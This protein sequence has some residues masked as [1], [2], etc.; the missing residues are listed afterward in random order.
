MIYI[1]SKLIPVSIYGALVTSLTCLYYYTHTITLGAFK[2][3][4]ALFLLLNKLV[5]DIQLAYFK[6]AYQ[7]AYDRFISKRKVELGQ[8]KSL[9][10]VCHLV[11]G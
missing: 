10:K 7:V 2:M 9:E 11:L 5:K 1:L 4:V 6:L 8:F 3:R